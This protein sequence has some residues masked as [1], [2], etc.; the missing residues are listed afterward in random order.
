MR[1]VLTGGGT[2][3]H[4]YP[5]IAIGQAI[6]KRWAEAEF[7]YVGTGTGMEARIVP[8]SGFDFQSVDVIGLKRSFSFQSIL[9]VWKAFRGLIR[10]GEILDRFRPCLVIGTGGYVCLPVVWAAARRGIPTIIHEQNAMPG[11]SNKFLAG[12]VNH[13]LLTFRESQQYF[14]A[15]YREKFIFTGLPVRPAILT[16]T[17]EEGY[18]QYGLSPKKL[19]LL[20]VGGSRGARSINKAMLQVYEKMLAKGYLEKSSHQGL[21]R[22]NM[23]SGAKLQVIHATGP[24]DYEEVR[25][26]LESLGIELG[27]SGNIIIRPYLHDMEYALACADLCVGRAGAAFLSELTAKGLPGIL[28]PYP[29]ATENH[30]E[31][32]ASSLVRQG[33]AEMILDSRLTGD[34]L[35][36]AIEEIIFDSPRRKK[37][38]QLSKEAG[39]VD[40][41]EKILQVVSRYL[42]PE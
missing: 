8:E 3:G 39:N 38:S 42:K 5:A 35:F 13:I 11:L 26:H 16:V 37:M 15:K 27:N 22:I 25:G 23:L 40:A 4:I 7:L 14:P 1:I 9:A 32:N 31:Y 34:N 21:P 2:G 10:A 41:V 18:A 12:K 19:T 24:L 28:I 20:V 6:K 36:A 30:Q 17:R 29:Y 33:A